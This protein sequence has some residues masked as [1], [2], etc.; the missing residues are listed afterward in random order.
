MLRLR[1]VVPTLSL[2]LAACG[3]APS[4]PAPRASPSN[5]PG[6][7]SISTP[8]PGPISSPEAPAATAALPSELADFPVPPGARLLP[9]EDGKLAT[10]AVEPGPSAYRFYLDELPAAGY[11][12][13]GAAPG[14]S[15]AIIRFADASG[16]AWQIDI[17]GDLESAVVEL[18]PERP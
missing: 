10:W 2:V 12:I 14:G 3:T 4:T 1:E 5:T 11:R 8:A 13:T 15:V 9:R 6:E 17:G 18:G 7:A 16:T